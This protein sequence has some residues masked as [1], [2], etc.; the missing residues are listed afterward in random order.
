MAACRLFQDPLIPAFPH[1]INNTERWEETHLEICPG[2]STYS[3]YLDSL[4]YPISIA[5]GR[6]SGVGRF[7][8]G[9]LDPAAPGW[10][11]DCCF[12]RSAS[13]SSMMRLP[14]TL[15]EW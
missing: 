6:S 14:R 13:I 1:Y 4:C 15:P 9:F 8:G 5:G 7:C 11:F 3:L 10:A 2:I 12:R